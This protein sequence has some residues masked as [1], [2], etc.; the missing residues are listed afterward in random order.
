MPSE[1]GAGD[2]D[3]VAAEEVQTALAGSPAPSPMPAGEGRRLHPVSI[4]FIL[5]AQARSLLLPGL[6]VLFAARG[7]DDPSVWAMVLIVPYTAVAVVRFLSFRY[8]YRPDELVIESGFVFR[9]RRHVPY[10]RIHNIASVENPLHRAFGVAEVR[11][12][13]AGG[14]EP[15]ARIRV[16]SLEA[17]EEMR[18]RVAAA[19]AQGPAA[20]VEG[21]AA[22]VGSAAAREAGA[23]SHAADDAAEQGA[24]AAPA[25][26]LVRLGPKDLVLYGLIDNRGMVVAGALLGVAWQLGL[27]DGGGRA[28]A[29]RSYEWW[30]VWQEVPGA[31]FELL[32]DSIRSG[33]SPF[34][35]AL[36]VAAAVA[37]FLVLVR[38]LSIGWAFYKLWGFRLRLA[39]RELAS[40]SGLLT[41]VRAA[42]PLHRIQTVT[43]TETPLHRL[44]RRVEVTA[45]TAGG[46]SRED[47][48]GGRERQRL[49]PILRRAE[50]PALIAEVL[51]GLDLAAVEWRPVDPRGERRM[52]RVGMWW[53]AA[54]SAAAAIG[55]WAAGISPWWAL[56]VLV[57]LG[58]QS[59][60][61]ARRRIR[62]YGWALTGDAVLYR[63]GGLWRNTT[64]AR[65]S[66]VQ[67]AALAESPFDRRWGMATLALDTAGAA[68]TSHR[69]HVPYLPRATARELLEEVDRRAATTAFRW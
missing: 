63:S 45:E 24:G 25:R 26:D 23:G 44:L 15:E 49:A 52:R 20:A 65:D 34:R 43:V 29:R 11:V 53:A 32:W 69:L 39:G 33:A 4:L 62:R 21:S 14:E 1:P 37:V 6:F 46:K 47:A 18:R 56:A 17:L 31:G 51:P 12:E 66:K 68:A 22:A 36:G 8:S 16:L 28:G 67:A 38:F 5:G 42:V 50:L 41:R 27:F 13:T 10:G 64:M 3:A 61:I 48:G 59:A 7:S 54:V 60:W 19:K 35:I 30:R 55:A 40:E 9:K 58:L 2:P 57:L